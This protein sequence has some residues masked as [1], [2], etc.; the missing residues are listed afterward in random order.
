MSVRLLISDLK[1]G[2]L[3]WINLDHINP[4]K[5]SFRLCIFYLNKIKLKRRKAFFWLRAERGSQRDVAIEIRDSK[6]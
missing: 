4:S 2:R 6:H 3:S 5:K 1:I